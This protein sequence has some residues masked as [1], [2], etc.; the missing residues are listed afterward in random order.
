MPE[1]PEFWKVWVNGNV[2]DFFHHFLNG[3]GSTPY[4]HTYLPTYKYKKPCYEIQSLVCSGDSLRF[5]HAA[6]EACK[7]S[8]LFCY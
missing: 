7:V 1:N 3:G 6:V 2:D 4:L 8:K 5:W